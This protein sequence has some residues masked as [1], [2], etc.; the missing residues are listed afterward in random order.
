MARSKS[1]MARSSSPFFNQSLP[2]SRYDM[3]ESARDVCAVTLG[4]ASSNP[5]SPAT[6]N[7][8][9]RGV[10]RLL[11]P[12]DAYF[13]LTLSDRFAFSGKRHHPV[14]QEAIDALFIA[15][16]PGQIQRG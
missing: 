16:L 5:I 10:I 13:D 1:E 6:D 12:F 2:R 4:A 3:A 11:L 8:N 14:S 9:P 7:T 15:R